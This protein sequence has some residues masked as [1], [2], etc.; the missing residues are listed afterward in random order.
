MA[1]LSQAGT[2]TFTGRVSGYSRYWK[3]TYNYNTVYTKT[4]KNYC[5]LCG[6]VNTL[7]VSPKRTA[8]PEGEVSCY[9]N[10]C[11]ADYDGVTGQDKHAGH[12]WG[13]L[14]AADGSETGVATT[15]STKTITH[16]FDIDK[17]FQAYVRIEYSL[18]PDPNA[19]RKKIQFNFS[20]DAPDVYDSFTGLNP[21]WVNMATKLNRVNVLDK[22]RV[23]NG[24]T[25]HKKH[26]YLRQI[27]FCH[28]APHEGKDENK[29]WDDSE[30][31]DD[32]SCKM[33][34]NE[35]GFS[36]MAEVQPQQLGASGKSILENLKDLTEKTNY[37]MQM[38]YGK[39]RYLDNANFILNDF[40]SLNEKYVN[41][42]QD[43]NMLAI[44]NIT[45]NPVTTVINDSIR[46]F[47]TQDD[48][49]DDSTIKYN[50]VQSRD[51]WLVARYGDCEDVETISDT[52]SPAQAYYEANTNEKLVQNR[53]ALNDI[54]FSYTVT[55]EGVPDVKVGNMANCVFDNPI[56]NDTK[57][58]Q[59]I[60]VKYN[61]KTRPDLRTVLGVGE[62]E[63]K[64]KGKRFMEDQRREQKNARSVYTGGA[65][66]TDGVNYTADK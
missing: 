57:D 7:T 14:V 2:I 21:A 4:W 49:T 34:L 60:E 5:P 31:T 37:I 35:V 42:R 26:Y 8:G 43:S 23:I 39:H 65:V 15:D 53:F 63:R 12:S 13:C 45:Y 46:I 66:Y 41:C 11:G 54:G 17:P 6:R 44:D 22:L 20:E 52:V 3:G 48:P 40:D 50:Y 1:D 16:G 24:D 25:E 28:T 19:P 9:P 10:G 58:I 30:G 61:P 18:S 27:S 59:S 38:D 64:L 51:P 56:M 62:M 29:P 32:S 47:K 36:S 55:I 33:I